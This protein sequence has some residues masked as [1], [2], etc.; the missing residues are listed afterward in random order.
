MK[1][2]S[3]TNKENLNE[4]KEKIVSV[5]KH[6]SVNETTLKLLIKDT[7]DLVYYPFETTDNQKYLLVYFDDIINKEILDRDV[8][9]AIISGA[10]DNP[11]DEN[12][13]HLKYL[14]SIISFT[15]IKENNDIDQIIKR[16]MGGD[17]IIFAQGMEIALCLPSQGWQQRS[18]MEP[19]A[20]IITKGPR[21]GF[22]ETLK[23]NRSMIRRKVKNTSLVFES[24]TKGNQTNSDIN[25]V[26][27]DNLVNKDVLALLKKRLEKID[28]DAILD[29]GYIEELIEDDRLSPFNTTG[30]TERPDVVV[31]KIL[32]GRI[33][34]MCTG[35]PIVLT[36]PHLFIENIQVNEDY[37]TGYIMASINRGIRFLSFLLTIFTPGMYVAIATNHHELIPTKLLISFIGSR[38]GVPFPTIIE[39]LIM[40][41]IFELLRESGLRL[42]KGLGQTISI[43]GALVLGQAAVEAKFI[44]AP[45]VIIIA[46]TAITSF[47]FYKINSLLIITRV[48]IAFLGAM[49]GLYGVTLGMICMFIYMYSLQSFGIPY[50]RYLG[51]M[52]GQEVKDT[53]VRAPWWYMHLR[54]KV[55]TSR[56]VVREGYRKEK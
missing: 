56:N 37:Y 25:I 49:F 26:Y 31:G 52:K 1:K 36:V 44:S 33:G 12:S 40:I 29:S 21:E 51:S 43:V 32:E 27:I 14:K 22:V 45:V 38:V 2:S 18:I 13:N 35:S 9:G 55:L 15:N 16:L 28:I 19:E 3:P 50:M 34:I 20:E 8:I 11:M 42:P 7:I 17:V 39:I 23:V 46:I 10:T 41:V 4:S 5:S 53:L 54:P 30:Y 48:I 24:I 6:L 47:I